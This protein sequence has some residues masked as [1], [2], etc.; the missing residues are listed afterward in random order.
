MDTLVSHKGSV[1]ISGYESEL[2]SYFLKGWHKEYF[3]AIAQTG[4]K[5]KEVL[6]MNFEPKG[7]IELEER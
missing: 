3:G 4:G 2:Y 1:L 6:W 7:Q 5:R